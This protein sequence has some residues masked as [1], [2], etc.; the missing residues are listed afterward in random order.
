ME[1]TL[2]EKLAKERAEIMR[3]AR[4]A[5]ATAMSRHTLP[6]EVNVKVMEL[7]ID[8]Q[9]DEAHKVVMDY[10]NATTLEA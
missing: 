3:L 9:V 8:A 4:V 10:L 7:M 5:P 1:L 6:R 2:I